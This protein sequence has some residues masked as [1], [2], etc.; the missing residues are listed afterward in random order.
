MAYDGPERRKGDQPFT[1]PER[2]ANTA[3]EIA[4]LRE[5]VLEL[6]GRVGQLTGQLEE[7]NSIRLRQ[8]VLD[9]Q[10]KEAFE[11]ASEALAKAQELESTTAPRTEV[12][13]GLDRERGERHRDR[14]RSGR[15]GAL[16]ALLIIALAVVAYRQYTF[17]RST[18]SDLNDLKGH[19]LG[20]CQTRNL[21]LAEINV[22][23]GIV[24]AIEDGIEPP[25]GGAAKKAELHAILK[26]LPKPL[27]C[28]RIYASGK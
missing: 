8:Q 5:N 28:Q 25:P 27:D 6:S 20:S 17:A 11:Q 10:A 1:G 26:N 18:R 14:R 13:E 19:S 21:Q 9:G 15:V 23:V 4:Q 7:V 12:N 22:I 3:A 16:M 24:A 2:R